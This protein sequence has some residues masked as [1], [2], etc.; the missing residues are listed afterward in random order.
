MNLAQIGLA[1]D[2]FKQIGP[3]FCRLY[4][5]STFGVG[6]TATYVVEA[7]GKRI[8]AKMVNLH[9]GQPIRGSFDMLKYPSALQA[10]H[11]H[12]SDAFITRDAIQEMQLYCVE[13]HKY[14]PQTFAY[15]TEYGQE[16]F[17]SD[18]D[19]LHMENDGFIDLQAIRARL[20]AQGK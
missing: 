20:Q 10:L 1:Y 19:E 5:G 17:Y 2:Q 4:V 15:N 6:T 13:A 18:I 14:P 8:F 3:L 16:I 11:E 12:F 9:T 7:G